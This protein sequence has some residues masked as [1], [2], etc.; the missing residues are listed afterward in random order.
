MP[1]LLALIPILAGAG[2][3]ATTG[4]SIANAVGGAP[5][6]PTAPLPK[7]PD[8]QAQQNLNARVA[9]QEPN[10]QASGSGDLSPAYTS[11]IAQILAGTLGQPGST[12]AGNAATGQNFSPVNA[13]P[14]NAA[15][16]GGD[17]GLSNF[18]NTSTP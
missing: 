8:A 18:L 6:P 14:T 7:P 1:Q 3:L 15:V 12:A 17:I 13:Q 9:Q 11:L 5:K 4:L 16:T 2:G 10:L